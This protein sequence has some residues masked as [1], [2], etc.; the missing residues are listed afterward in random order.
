ME[1]FSFFDYR[2]CSLVLGREPSRFLGPSAGPAVVPRPTREGRYGEL[3][4]ENTG[5]TEPRSRTLAF[6]ARPD[7]ELAPR[8]GRSRAVAGVAI[9]RSSGTPA[10]SEPLV[11]LG[12]IDPTPNPDGRV[13]ARGQGPILRDRSDRSDRSS[14]TDPI[15]TDRNHPDPRPN[16]AVCG[17]WGR[18]GRRRRE[19]GWVWFGSSMRGRVGC[20]ARRQRRSMGA[21]PEGM[22]S[23]G[24]Q[25]GRRSIVERRGEV[26]VRRRRDPG[27]NDGVGARGR[28][29]QGLQRGGRT[30]TMRPGGPQRGDVLRS[31]GVQ[32]GRLPMIM[33]RPVVRA[34]ISSPS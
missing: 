7:G 31:S 1:Y 26:G 6:P 33:R 14:R 9:G 13:S 24:L 29:D 15:Q 17:L 19:F 3:L 2:A 12:G 10:R 25:R 32:R 18:R 5:E 21:G 20:R 4:G 27:A 8:I 22:R 28:R 16:R 11:S 23:G 30:K 34:R